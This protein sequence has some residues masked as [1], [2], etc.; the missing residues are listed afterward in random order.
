MILSF[1]IFKTLFFPNRKSWGAEILRECSPPP[2][3]TCHVSHVTWHVSHDMCHMSHFTWHVSHVM[4][5][6]SRGMCH[7]SGV[8][9]N[10]QSIGPLGRNVRL[11]VCLSVRVCVFTFEVP[12]KRLFAPTSRSRM[13][14]IFRDSES[15]GKSSWKKWSHIWTFLFENCLKSLRLTKHGRNH[16]SD[17]LETSGWRMYRKFWHIC[18]RFWVFAFWMI[19]SLFKKNRVFGYSWS[20]RKPRFPMD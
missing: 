7:M 15:L 6:M 16:T 2:C 11:S 18:R 20:T 17:G 9:C 4:C 13:S 14:N 1:R 12:F 19:F 8:T 10:F 3:V 5:L